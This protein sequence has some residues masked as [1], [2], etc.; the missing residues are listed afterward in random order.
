MGNMLKTLRTVG[1]V[2]AIS[3]LL[4]VLV[5]MPL[6]YLANQPL[7]VTYVGMIHGILFVAYVAAIAV[8]LILR[9]ITFKQSVLAFIA[10]LLPF[11]PFVFDR[12]LQRHTA[13]ELPATEVQKG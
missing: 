8:T 11:G 1:H 3:Y 4:L 2:E 12:Y 5:A 6:K 10:S 7:M 13:P 9:K